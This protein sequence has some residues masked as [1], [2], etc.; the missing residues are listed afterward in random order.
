MLSVFAG[1][2]RD[3]GRVFAEAFDSSGTDVYALVVVSLLPADE[4]ERS[5]KLSLLATSV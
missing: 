5:V 1:D 4:V 2:E 3:K